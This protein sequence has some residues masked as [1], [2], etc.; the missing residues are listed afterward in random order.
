MLITGSLPDRQL[1]KGDTARRVHCRIGSLENIKYTHN[2]LVYVHCRIGSLES[3]TR[4]T[5]GAG[6]SSLPD[7]QL[8]KITLNHIQSIMRSLPDR[9]LRN[10]TM[11]FFDWHAGSLPDRQLRN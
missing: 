1:R 10:S 2:V 5:H 8:R 9:Q 7:R 6:F 4:R 3:E 11:R